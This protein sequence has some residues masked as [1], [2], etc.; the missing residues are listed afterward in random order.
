MKVVWS[1][2]ATSR[3]V[4]V[5]R[6]IAQ[7]SPQDAKRWVEGIFGAVEGLADFPEMGKPGRDVTTPGVRE[8]VFGNYRVFYEVGN[9]VDILTV[10]RCSELLDEDEFTK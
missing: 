1:R 3:V 7:D 9:S 10:R 2:R 8:L 6:F 5:A 4:E